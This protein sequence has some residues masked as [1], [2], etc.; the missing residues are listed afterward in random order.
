MTKLKQC[1]MKK[2]CITIS[3][4]A[5]LLTSCTSMLQGMAAGMSGYRGYGGYGYGYGSSNNMST[6]YFNSIDYGAI[7]SAP[8]PVSAPTT[9]GYSSP[10]SSGT[11]TSSG[12]TSSSSSFCRTCSNTKKCYSCHGSGMRTDNSFGTG[13][14]ATVKC[15][16]CGGSGRCP[17]CK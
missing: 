14:S 15:G 7:L 4:F 5:M 13:T 12:S 2:I 10:Y 1:Y 3:L 9:S 11:S 6:S 16:I 8:A 17:S